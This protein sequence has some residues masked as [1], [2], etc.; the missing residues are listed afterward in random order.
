MQRFPNKGPSFP[1]RFMG[2]Q[3]TSVHT[4]EQDTLPKPLLIS[5][6]VVPY[7]THDGIGYLGGL[8]T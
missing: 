8:F 3:S 6:Q 1:L 7:Q 4:T 2:R 5:K